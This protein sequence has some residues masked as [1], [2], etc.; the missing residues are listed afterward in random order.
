MLLAQIHTLQVLTAYCYRFDSRSARRGVRAAAQDDDIGENTLAA[1]HLAVDA[2]GELTMRPAT[3]RKLQT[4]FYRDAVAEIQSLLTAAGLGGPNVVERVQ[5][6]LGERVRL[7]AACQAACD[8]TVLDDELRKQLRAA[9]DAAQ[10]SESDRK[11][12]A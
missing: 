5:S 6:L 8:G 10:A 1:D 11:N 2:R 12:A 3:A 9:L 7:R 4:F